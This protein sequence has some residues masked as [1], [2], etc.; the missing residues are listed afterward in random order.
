MVTRPF[1]DKIIQ[2]K[3][4]V[5]GLGASTKGNILLQ[6][7]GLD[8][9]KIPF[10]SE[11][12]PEKVGL[13]CLGSDIELISEERARLMNPSAFIVLPWNFK[14]EIVEREKEYLNNQ[15]CE[16]SSSTSQSV[17]YFVTDFPQK[18]DELGSR[19]LGRQLNNVTHIPIV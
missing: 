14:D 2:S 13:K 1:V 3:K 16:N 8:K 17:K 10:I 11:R 4:T 15:N 18:F 12:N 9:S 5:L 19:F 6:H 7:F